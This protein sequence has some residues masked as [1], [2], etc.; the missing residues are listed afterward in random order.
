MNTYAKGVLMGAVLSLAAT[1][2]AVAANRK[3]QERVAGFEKDHVTLL[4]KFPALA[5][6]DG[7]VRSECAAKNE[8]K[9]ASSEFCGCASA[10]TMGLWRSGIDPNM[11]PRLTAYL[12]V[13]TDEGANEFVRYQGPE[14]YG[15]LCAEAAK[16]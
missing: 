9:L 4:A 11:V 16:R 2:S 8:G 7:V 10:V 15:P 6:V 12:K 3:A 13:P 14:L 1:G 5:K